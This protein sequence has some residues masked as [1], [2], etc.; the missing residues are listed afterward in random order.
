MSR[1]KFDM[2]FKREVIEYMA[3]GGTAYQAAKHFSTKNKTHY[4]PSNFTRWYNNRDAIFDQPASKSRVEGAGRKPLLGELEDIIYNEIMEMRSANMKVS[5]QFIHDRAL[6]LAADSNVQL[7]ASSHFVTDFMRRHKLSLRRTTNAT[8]LTED[9]I[10][11]NGLNY[12]NYVREAK[13]TINESKTALMD[14]T[15]VYLEDPRTQTIEIRGRKHVVMKSTGFSSMRLTVIGAVWANGQKIPPCVIHK[16]PYSGQISV[17]NGLTYVS[18]P[19]AW[20]DA[21]LLI[22]WIDY[23]FPQ[24]DQSEGKTIVWDACRAHI[25]K[26]VKAHCAKRNIRLI[27]IPG[28]MTSLLQA[29]DIGIYK[30]FK[31][32]ISPIIDEWKNG[33]TVQYTKGGNPKPPGLSVINDWVKTA[34]HRIPQS[35]IRLG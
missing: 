21:P 17:A 5:R 12:M 11:S 9:K 35:T 29:G 27:V 23:I 16:G 32:N 8:T 28:G 6:Q 31:D 26:D 3:K 1:R 24:V 15:A 4:D 19:K 18:Q 22:K 20:V 13:L 10:I 30:C 25:S 2:S 33:N 34:W 7:S 14:E